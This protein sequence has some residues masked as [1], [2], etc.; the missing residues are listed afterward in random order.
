[1]DYRFRSMSKT[2]AKTGRPLEPGSTCYSVLIEKNGEFQRQ[3]FSQEGWD[4]LPEEAIGFWKCKV[5]LPEAKDAATVDPEA[6][7][8][9][10]EQLQESPNQQQERLLYVLALFL[11]QR[12]RLRLDGSAT[13]D[14]VEYLQL[15]GSRGEGPF[16]VR[17]QKLSQEEISEL[18][19]AL[20]HQLTIGWEAA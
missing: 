6:L 10:F 12:R 11:L 17:D 20:N 14:D 19:A 7:M 13:L 18:T 5:P 1:M 9:Y 8:Q 2:C 16:E 3:D 15:S 4:G